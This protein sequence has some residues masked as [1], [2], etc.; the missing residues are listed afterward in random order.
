MAPVTSARGRWHRRRLRLFGVGSPKSGTHSLEAVFA[1]NY[2]SAHEPEA[3]VLVDLLVAVAEGRTGEDDLR[4]YLRSRERRLRLEVNCAGLNGLVV[5]QLVEVVPTARFVLTLRDPYDWLA[6]MIDHSLRGDPAPGY[7]RLRHLRYQGD[8]VHPREE[9]DLA[10]NGLFT[11]DGYLHSWA[12][13]NERALAVVPANRLLVVR[14]DQLGERLG[15]IAAFA[16]VPLESL[17]ATRTHEYA[18]PERSGLLDQLDPAYVRQ[19]VEYHGRALMER[20]FPER[21]SG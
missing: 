7:L 2:R 1:E 8:R 5:D 11:L 10:D 16:G 9:K 15:D 14:T 13:R 17:D 21:L 4:R 12:E 3:L 19:R 18:A 6:S 20:F